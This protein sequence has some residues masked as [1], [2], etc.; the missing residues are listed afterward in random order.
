MLSSSVRVMHDRPYAGHTVGWEELRLIALT[1]ASI[2][3]VFMLGGVVL[4]VVLRK[5]LPDRHLND[6]S[7]DVI[8]LG[9]GLIATMTALVLGLLITSAKG[10]YDSARGEVREMSANIIFLDRLLEQYG[11]EARPIRDLLRRMIDPL[12]ES[13]WRED[14][15]ASVRGAPLHVTA[16]GH[17]VLLKIN[18]LAPKSEAQGV[19]R[20]QIVQTM[21]RLEL[22]R[23][24]LFEQAEQRTPML[25]VVVVIFWL[26]VIFASFSLFSPLN[27]S[28]MVALVVIALSASCAIFLFFEMEQPF[29]G[30]MQVSSAGLR[31]AVA[32]LAP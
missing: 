25:F 26:T 32:P 3:C 20:N 30:V 24:M 10:T 11:P 12:V 28:S 1:M 31:A 2:A 9:T 5:A 19:I 23:S 27:L 16:A 4:G 14:R 22:L 6:H 15:L 8:R 18:E 17:Q 7:K 13:V 29:D 21:A